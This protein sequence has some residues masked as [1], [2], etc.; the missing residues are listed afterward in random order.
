[1]ERVLNDLLYLS[2]REFHAL[3]FSR[4]KDLERERH[5]PNAYGTDE[6]QVRKA[7]L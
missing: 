4:I 3:A 7:A 2:D 5:N 1:M 6:P